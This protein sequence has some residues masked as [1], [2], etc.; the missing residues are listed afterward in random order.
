MQSIPDAPESVTDIFY[1]K[2]I[3]HLVRTGQMESQGDLRRMRSS[4]VRLPSLPLSTAELEELIAQGDFWTLGSF[5]SQGQGVAQDYVTALRWYRIAAER[6]GVWSQFNVGR[7]YMNGN[8]VEKDYKEAYFWFSLAMNG[9]SDKRPFRYWLE[10]VAPKLAPEVR[11]E[12]D[13]QVAAWRP[14]VGFTG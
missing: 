2:R 12:V 8:G 7:F 4:E 5:Y 1:V 10:Q 3:M 13:R 14:T 11:A 6:G 9:S